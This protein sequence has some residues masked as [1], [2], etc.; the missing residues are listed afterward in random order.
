ME[1]VAGLIQKLGDDKVELEL[2]W[3]GAYY[4]D[5]ET[6]RN[7]EGLHGLFANLYGSEIIY[8][9]RSSGKKQHLFQESKFRY[10]SLERGLIELGVLRGPL[11]SAD[12]SELDRIAKEHCN[13]Y[14]GILRDESKLQYLE[15]AENLMIFKK[16][17]KG[18]GNLKYTYKG[19]IPFKLINRGE[20]SIL[21]KLGLKDYEI[22][23]GGI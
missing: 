2:E 6:P 22:L 23:L 4:L 11:G 10:K 9:G 20:S 21:A 16:K 8:I 18:N 19:I 7:M 12:R 13:K 1:T 17:P 14:V 3:D 5:E 15:S